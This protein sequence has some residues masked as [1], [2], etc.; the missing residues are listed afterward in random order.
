[1]TVDLSRSEIVMDKWEVFCLWLRVLLI[2]CDGVV[3]AACDVPYLDEPVQ[4]RW[5]VPEQLS[6]LLW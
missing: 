1:M 3:F 2:N 6:T 4:Y 5:L